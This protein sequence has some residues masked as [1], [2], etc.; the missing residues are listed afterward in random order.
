MAG[1]GSARPAGTPEPII[2]RINADVVDILRQPAIAARFLQLGGTAAP[3]TPEEFGAFVRQEI[4]QWREV[5]RI[6]N[7]RLEG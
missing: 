4:A 5:A 2:R 1:P 6:A 3:G 7:V